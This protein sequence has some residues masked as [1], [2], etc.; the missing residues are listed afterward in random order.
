MSYTKRT[1]C[2]TI[3]KIQIHFF[4]LVYK[5]NAAESFYAKS[6]FFE[7]CKEGDLPLLIGWLVGCG[8]TSH[9]AIFQLY[10]DETVV[11]FPNFD[12]LPG[13]QCHGQLGVFSVSSLHWT[14]TG[15]SEDVFYLLAIRGPTRGEGMPGI[16]PGSPDPQSSLLPLRHCGGHLFW[17]FPTWHV[18]FMTGL[19]QT[20][21]NQ[22][23]G[24][25]GI[26]VYQYP[27]THG[28]V[29]F[30]YRGRIITSRGPPSTTTQDNFHQ[31]CVDLWLY[32]WVF[33]FCI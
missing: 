18:W 30:K 25:V 4:M 27:W 24:L 2:I 7:R 21:S 6:P 19:T 31:S 20:S 22:L 11:Q 8:L 23:N 13:T 10:S 5:I 3:L 28:F 15:T 29:I 26:I 9:S 1:G 16:E 17:T 12:L 33:W 14:G 32:E